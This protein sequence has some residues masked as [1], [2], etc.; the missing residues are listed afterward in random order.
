[1]EVEIIIEIIDFYISILGNSIEKISNIGSQ[2]LLKE[3]IVKTSIDK[4]LAKIEILKILRVTIESLMP[5]E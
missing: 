3:E 4:L 2:Q 5:I 1:M